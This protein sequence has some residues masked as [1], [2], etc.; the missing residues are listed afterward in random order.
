MSNSSRS[1]PGS[2]SLWFMATESEP[3]SPSRRGRPASARSRRPSRRGDSDDGACPL[4]Y[5]PPR[6][7]EGRVGGRRRP[8]SGYLM[9]RHRRRGGR[10]RSRR[11]HGGDAVLDGLLD[12]LER[13]HLDL[14][15]AFA[16][17]AEFHREVLKS[18]RLVG[19]PA[20]LEDAPFTVVEHLKRIGKRRTAIVQLLRGS[21][22]RFLAFT[23]VHQ[24]VLPLARI[25]VIADRSVERSV[26][27]EPPIHVDDVLF[28]HAEPLGYQ[29]DLIG[30]H[31]PFLQRGDSALGLAQVEEELFL[32]GGG[33]HLDERPRPQNVFLDGGFDPPHRVGGEAEAFFRF[34]ALH[35]LH[36]A[37][38][39]LRNHFG[40]R[41]AIAPIAHGD[42]GNK[43]QVAGHE[44]VSRNAVA[45]LPPV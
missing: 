10:A 18:H 1:G 21:E 44:L 33:A 30:A 14:A 24:P 13:S 35:R 5:P 22:R 34:E 3:L 38:I 20:R 43:A 15:H 26:A 39:A 32:V 37:D 17:Y 9:R 11:F 8:R 4:P 23:V 6:A 42:F 16:R 36:Q 19:K 7:G 41:K 40:N 2:T 28:G 45:M 12:L 29:L 25:T 31:I 27:T